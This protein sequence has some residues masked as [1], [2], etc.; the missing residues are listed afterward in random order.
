MLTMIKEDGA[1]F[2]LTTIPY[3]KNYDI[4]SG[5]IGTVNCQEIEEHVLSKIQ[6]IDRFSA[7]TV[8]P[9]HT[10]A[11]TPLMHIINTLG[12]EAI[13]AWFLGLVIMSLLINDTQEWLVVK[14]DWM[15]REFEICFYW[16]PEGK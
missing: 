15:H 5:K 13:S 3:K 12:D 10:W 4:W 11:D 1:K 8:F 2:P 7:A 9:K 14:T 6:G 16:I